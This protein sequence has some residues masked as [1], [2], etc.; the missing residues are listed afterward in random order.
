MTEYQ[1]QSIGKVARDAG[2]S[3]IAAKKNSTGQS[4]SQEWNWLKEAFWWLK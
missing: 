3:V 4:L 1:S 2:L